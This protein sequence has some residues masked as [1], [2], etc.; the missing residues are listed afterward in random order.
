MAD[1]KPNII[2]DAAEAAT[3]AAVAGAHQAIAS[4]AKNAA[5][6]GA[7]TSEFKVTLLSSALVGVGAGLKAL[8]V[9]PGPWTIPAG[10]LAVAVTSASYA[11]GR[12]AVKAAALNAAGTLASAAGN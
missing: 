11:L 3:A 1:P 4:A 5:G 8:A 2:A 6:S 9:I 7:Y 10:I 12:S